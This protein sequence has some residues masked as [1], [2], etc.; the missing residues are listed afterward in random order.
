MLRG[1]RIYESFRQILFFVK[2]CEFILS[3]VQQSGW[4]Y[5]NFHQQNSESRS[6]CA[7]DKEKVIKGDMIKSPIL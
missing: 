2:L 7:A 3:G 5:E 6:Q 4:D 1:Y